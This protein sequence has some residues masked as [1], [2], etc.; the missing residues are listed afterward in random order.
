[1]QID[2]ESIAVDI[3]HMSR[4]FDGGKGEAKFLTGFGTQYLPR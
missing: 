4:M 3:W 2:A 1:M